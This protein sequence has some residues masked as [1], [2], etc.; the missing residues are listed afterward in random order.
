M[1]FEAPAGAFGELLLGE[2]AKESR[3]RPTFLVGALGEELPDGLDARQAQ[4]G[5]HE[6]DLRGIDGTHEPLPARA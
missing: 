3:C 2:R 5:E 4:L 6:V 1:T